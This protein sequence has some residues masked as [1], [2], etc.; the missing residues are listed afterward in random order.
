MKKGKSVKFIA[1]TA[2]E[3][4]AIAPI[5]LHLHPALEIHLSAE[6][7]FQLGAGTRGDLFE[8]RT[9]FADDH[10][11]MAVTFAI[12]IGIDIQNRTLFGLALTP[13]LNVH[14]NTMG[15]VK[16]AGHY[17]SRIRRIWPFPEKHI[18][19]LNN[20]ISLKITQN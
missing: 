19:D 8:H 14:S 4:L 7:L 16:D 17:L 1:E 2:E 6:Q 11:L 20:T 3:T 12:D 5:L 10:T 13:A 18:Q 15:K 9:L